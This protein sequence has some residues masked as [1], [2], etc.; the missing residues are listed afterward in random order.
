[1][2]QFL[3]H[4]EQINI[5]LV[6][7][8]AAHF[9]AVQNDPLDFVAEFRAQARQVFRKGLLLADGKKTK[10][11]AF[12]PRPVRRSLLFQPFRAFRF[13]AFSNT[14]RAITNR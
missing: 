12:L 14:L 8:I 9:R 1:M 10:P 13:H 5:R 6:V 3:E 4:D 2:I 7:K 11:V